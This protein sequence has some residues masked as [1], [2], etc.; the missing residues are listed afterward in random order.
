MKLQEA[1]WENLGLA[2]IL[3]AGAALRLHGLDWDG[4]QW[5]H[6]DERQIYF[7]TMELG[8]PSSLAEALSPASPLNPGFF[9]YGS[10]PF[11]LLK[12]VTALVAPVWPTLGD[13]DNLHLIGRCLA[14]AFDLGT[15]YLTYRLASRLLP[16]PRNP[17]GLNSGAL[18]ATALTS[19]AVLHV[20]LAHFY[21][22]DPLLTFFVLLTLNLAVDVAR[23]KSRW[24]KAGLGLAL[25]LALATKV[26][27]A[28]LI[29]PI[30][31]ACFVRET[32]R[33]T[34]RPEA[35]AQT[36]SAPSTIVATIRCTIPMLILASFVFLVIQPY[37]VIDWQTFLSD[38]MRESQIAWGWLDAPYTRQYASTLP[39]LYT[40]WQTALWGI[41]LPLG[42]IVWP[43]LGITIVRWTRG[44]AWTDTLL[45]AWAGPYLA[46]T[47]LMYAKYLRYMLPLVPVLCVLVL[48]YFSN[49]RPRN[50]LAAKPLPSVSHSASSIHHPAS[51]V[52]H[53]LLAIAIIAL[54]VLAPTAY[55][56]AFST[57]YTEPHSWITA[58]RWFYEHVPQGSTLA[59]E[60]WDTALPLPLEIDGQPRRIE[61][62]VVHTLPLYAEPDDTTK[63][64][65]IAAD[66]AQTDYVIIAS[67]RL[68]GSI[69]RQP[70]RYPL[71]TRYYELLFS[72]E[73]GFE[74]AME[75]TR[76]PEWLNPRLAPLPGAAP[77]FVIP[78]ESFVVYDHPRALVFRNIEKAPVEELLRRL[79]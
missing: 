48:Q 49:R 41:G 78:D 35:E 57:I 66:L 9:A 52:Q 16:L 32:K 55:A 59:L 77:Q 64:V 34:P 6:P 43:A 36:S 73:L 68:Y 38:T 28:L 17:R 47:G 1:R 26:V 20:Q 12:L 53:P 5:L 58:S 31:A 46:I 70:D 76:G 14:I 18:L 74:L 27:A 29:V 51:I 24:W 11:Y 56:L 50:T 3:L 7:V 79:Q 61:E 39:Y 69:P 44:G 45:L 13:P 40:M 37:A 30:I 71:A 19:L 8:W 23:G 60:E 75:F 63:W 72:G 22:S 25:G 10:L 62:Y 33:I 67:R 15:I 2:L 21:T 54:L 42:L 4:G 65:Q